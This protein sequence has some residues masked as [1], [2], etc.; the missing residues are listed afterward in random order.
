MSQ[1]SDLPF[2]LAQSPTFIPAPVLQSCLAS[3][4]EISID[5]EWHPD[6]DE[7]QVSVISLAWSSRVIVIHLSRFNGYSETPYT[8][9][10]LPTLATIL[11]KDEIAK[12][13]VNMEG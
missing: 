3:A 4:T 12:F 10:C 2:P 8:G 13:G 11:A 6:G 5:L 9:D 1:L 7:N